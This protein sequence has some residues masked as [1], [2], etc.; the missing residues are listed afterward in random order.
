MQ[1]VVAMGT[2][3]ALLTF[4]KKCNYHYVCM[5]KNNRKV[6]YKNN[7]NL[8]VKIISMLFNKK[9]YRFYPGTDFYLKAITAV[10]I[11]NKFNTIGETVCFLQ[12]F[13]EIKVNNV[14]YIV[15]VSSKEYKSKHVN[16]VTNPIATTIWDKL[17]A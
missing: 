15:N 8:N 10:Q 13:V 7:F 1:K 16:D 11:K 3:I 4:L 17:S 9:Q 14:L 12:E 2:T 6:I 5:L